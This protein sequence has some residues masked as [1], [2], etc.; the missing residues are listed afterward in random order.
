MTK[1]LITGG[2]DDPFLPHIRA[3]I[4]QASEI[5]IAVAFI[6]SSGLKLIYPALEEAVVER[7]ARL[8]VLTSD[9]LDVTDPQAL[10]DLMLLVD[11]GADARVFCAGA[12]Q[13]FHLKAYI[14]AGGKVGSSQEGVAFVGSSNISHPALTSGIEWNYSVSLGDPGSQGSLEHR[15]RFAGVPDDQHPRSVDA[16]GTAQGFDAGPADL[17]GQL[18]ELAECAE[19]LGFVVDLVEQCG[20]KRIAGRGYGE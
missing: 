15:T 18:F 13:S 5:E 10:R 12:G 17:Q 20:I 9:Y 7:Q 4:R 3:A 6:K 16:A 1:R 8:S 2:S 11:R 19:W 14:F